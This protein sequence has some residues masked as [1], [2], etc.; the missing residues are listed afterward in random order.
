MMD[1]LIARFPAQ[2]QEALT[3]GQEATI[4]A[5]EQP[6]HQVYVAGLGGS[7]IGANFVAEFVREE[8]KVPYTI[9]KGYEIPA[10]VGKNTL[11]IASS[12]SGNTEETLSAFEQM[13]E[14]GAKIV[15]IASGG[16]LIAK[17]KD[18]GLDYI[19]LPGGWPS[20]RACLGF[21]MV[22]QLFVLHK[23]G[24][25]SNRCIEQV[26]A[27][28]ELLEQEKEAIQD[29]A[30]DIARDLLGKLP[31]IYTTDRMEAVAVRLRQQLNENSK[32][33]CWHHVVP[34]MNHNELVGWR[35]ENKDLAVIYLRNED[36]YQRNQ[37]RI[38][39][40]KEIISSYTNTIIEINSKGNA[41]VERAIYLVH[42]S[43]WISFHLAA[44]REVDPVEIKV[45]D[46]L[47]GE[48]AKV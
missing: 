3:I 5:S 2:L 35:Q 44:M 40:N 8:C 12:Y 22:Q 9:G 36:D 13:V 29:Q 32:I 34:E 21:S 27:A 10:H 31:I 16:K 11:A 46:Y 17:A 20:P 23:L 41:L 15:V 45:I 6:I 28:H 14:S 19:Q 4:H 7:G 26:K 43:D 38:N 42:L 30:K 47:K 37:V 39:I 33:L 18:L 1:A 25:I 48:L 24:L